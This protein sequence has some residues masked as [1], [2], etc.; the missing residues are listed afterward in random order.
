MRNMGVKG[1]LGALAGVALLAGCGGGGKD[2]RDDGRLWSLAAQEDYYSDE[3][4]EKNEAAREYSNIGT[5]STLFETT[6]QER[7]TGGSGEYPGSE[8]A[9][10]L[11]GSPV[12]EQERATLWLRQDERVPSPLPPFDALVARDIG[13]GKPLKKGPNGAWI[14]GT[15]G[16]ELGSGLASSVAPSTGSSFQPRESPE[17]GYIPPK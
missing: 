3:A 15:Y 5:S 16:V 8:Q 4:Q 11:P 12:N 17:R 9:I 14:Q 13:T 1:L 6:E 7:G 2:P 10:L